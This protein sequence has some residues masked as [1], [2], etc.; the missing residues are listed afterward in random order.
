MN[1]SQDI[2]LDQRPEPKLAVGDIVYYSNGNGVPVGAKV[3]IGVDWLDST[4]WRYYIDPTDT[5]WFCVREDQL[6]KVK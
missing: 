3:V 1:L 5:P 4:G 6:R 2:P